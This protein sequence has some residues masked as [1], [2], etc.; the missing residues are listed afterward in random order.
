MIKLKDGEV[1]FVIRGHEDGCLAAFSSNMDECT[2]KIVRIVETKDTA[3]VQ[4]VMNNHR[5]M[6]RK[7]RRAAER[8]LRKAAKT[9]AARATGAA[10]EG[11]SNTGDNC[12]TRQKKGGAA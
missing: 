8:A 7:A 9:K 2:C 4:R 6:C 1:T 11:A 3:Y 5:A 10:S 12:S